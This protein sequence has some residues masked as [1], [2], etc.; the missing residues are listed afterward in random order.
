MKYFL[1]LLLTLLS[2]QVHAY[3]ERDIKCLTD[4]VYHEARNQKP[5]VQQAVVNLVFSRTEYSL[6]P[7]SVCKVIYQPYQFSWTL[8]MPKVKE[9]E[10]YQ[11]INKRVRGW[12]RL[13]QLGMLDDPTNGALYFTSHGKRVKGTKVKMKL[14]D[15]T[16]ADPIKHRGRFITKDPLGDL[17]GKLQRG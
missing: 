11:V 13:K 4:N 14:G 12:V 16:F 3:T 1:F 17:I 7:N 6:Y 10:T 5:I 9:H 8:V 15:L 2:F